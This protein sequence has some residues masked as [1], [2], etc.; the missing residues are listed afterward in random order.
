MYLDKIINSTISEYLYE[1]KEQDVK[2]IV[3]HSSNKKFNEFDSS[4]ITNLGGSL[5]GEGFYFTDNIN[6]SKKF[7]NYTYKCEITLNNPLI[8][9]NKQTKE[10]LINL[11]ININLLKNDF[12]TILELINSGAYTTAFRYIRKHISFN[13]LKQKHDAVIGYA[14]NGGK[15]YVVYNPENIRIIE[16]IN[17]GD[18]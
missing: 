8:L 1:N 6:Y 7:G 15:E 14:E 12:N 13:E 16:M 4:K 10:Q 11:L 17:D 18:N 3:F 5:Y 9:T 2:Y